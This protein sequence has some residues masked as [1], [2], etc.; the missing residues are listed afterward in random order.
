MWP[1]H[2]DGV[3]TEKIFKISC[4]PAQLK[5]CTCE[6]LISLLVFFYGDTPCIQT[7][8]HFTAWLWVLTESDKDQKT[9]ICFDNPH[10]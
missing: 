9:A 8:L 5:I 10:A 6:Q 2:S 3:C 1:E 4:W 7:A